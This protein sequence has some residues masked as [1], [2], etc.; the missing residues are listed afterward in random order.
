ML[1][2]LV[3]LLLTAPAPAITIFERGK[4]EPTRARLVRSTAQQV[5]IAEVQPD[6]TT[7]ERTIPRSEIEDLIDPV[8]RERL[9]ALTPESP[10]AYRN[11]AEELAEKR[12]DPDAQAAAIRLYLIA[13]WLDPENLAR[14]CLLGM[15]GLARTPEEERKFRAM[16]YLHDPDHDR[17]LLRRAETTTPAPA[18]AS[19]GR[20]GLLR[21]LALRRQGN[22]RA[23][24]LN[25]DRLAVKEELQKYRDTLTYDEFAQPGLSDALIRKIVALELAL[26]LGA[27][28]STPIAGWSQVLENNQTAPI[29]ALRLE[30][31]TEFDPRH[32]LYRD[33][34]WVAP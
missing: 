24:L 12:V 10:Q 34:Q 4:A 17:R 23:A 30:T 18:A 14:S 5:T 22:R 13:A 15:T 27:A 9:E 6:G 31:L 19:E 33:G 1:A 2:I 29:P 21:A 28:P 8:S 20:A 25:I 26:E 7:R 16:A 3:L 11:Y 32:C